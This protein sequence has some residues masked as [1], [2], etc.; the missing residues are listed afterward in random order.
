MWKK[1]APLLIV[2]SV[3]MNIA[4]VGTWAVQVGRAH[5]AT[6]GTYDGPVWSPLHRMLNVTDEQWQQ[7][8]PRIVDY[9]G[10]FKVVCVDISGLRTELLDLIAADALDMEAIA[11]KQEQILSGKRRM[12]QLCAEHLL[13]EK[14][15][16]TIEQQKELFEMLR[17][18]C[19]V[20]SRL[21]MDLTGK[22]SDAPATSQDSS[23]GPNN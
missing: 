8:E 5:G 22:N 19:K 2:L 4:F 9:H 14:E 7:I 1:I 15:M 6:D 17:G 16:L 20:G 13:A 23:H 18:R 3:A 12:Q 21:M 10:K 11:D